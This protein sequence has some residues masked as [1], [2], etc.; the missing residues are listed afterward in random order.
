MIKREPAGISRIAIVAGIA[1]L[2]TFIFEG[3]IFLKSGITN[4]IWQREDL[5][6]G[7]ESLRALAGIVSIFYVFRYALRSKPA[8]TA[9]LIQSN[10]YGL[11]LFVFA[12]AWLISKIHADFSSDSFGKMFSCR[13]ARSGSLPGRGSLF[14]GQTSWQI[15]HPKTRFSIFSSSSETISPRS[16]MVR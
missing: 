8:T 4:G 5:P 1:L 15:S 14:Q 11:L 9:P 3:V 6:E 7:I 13:A 12:M 10:I 16:S 2:A